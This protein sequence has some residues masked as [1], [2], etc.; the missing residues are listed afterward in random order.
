MEDVIRK[1][2]G[3]G[4][5]HFLPATRLATALQG[6][7]LATNLFLLGY[8]YQ[9]GR[10]PVSLGAVLRAIELNGRA[11]EWNQR[12]FAW[13]RLAAHDR[14]AVDAAARPLMH[15]AAPERASETLDAIV[16]RRVELLTAYQNAAYA[17]RYR[18]VVERVAE[19]ERALGGGDDL[20]RA[21]A[22]YLYKVMAYKDEYEVARLYTDG[23]LARQLEREFEGRYKLR[24]HL[25][26]QFLPG[27]LAPRDPDT[28]RVK[29]WAIPAPLMLA[30]F[31][32][33]AALRFLRGTPFDPFGWTAHRRIERRLIGEYEAV[34]A[35]LAA[36][37]TA[38][39]RPLA[40]EIASLPEIV[41]GYDTVKERTLAEAKHKEQEL[42]AAFRRTL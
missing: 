2:A 11:A 42:L 28:G 31:R 5:A 4:A 41:R 3:L 12:A 8:A 40:V 25:S 10:V 36:G 34:V 26:P 24:V 32:S 38:E 15:G 22:R 7:A 23:S 37:L 35:E 9:L 6:D 21:V 16:A 39:N 18:A 29:K 14:A 17:A 13:G 20:A 27:F 33:M 19:R 30:G 1:A